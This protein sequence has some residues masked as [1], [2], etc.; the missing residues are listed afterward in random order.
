MWRDHIWGLAVCVQLLLLGLSNAYVENIHDLENLKDSEL[1][2][3]FNNPYGDAAKIPGEDRPGN[4][5]AIPF[6][7]AL[8]PP[9]T[10]IMAHSLYTLAVPCTKT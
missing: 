6:K 1:L 5:C 10:E 3:V 7:Y 9:N 4:A 8:Q 2:Q